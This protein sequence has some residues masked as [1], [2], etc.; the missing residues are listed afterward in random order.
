V[1]RIASSEAL[2]TDSSDYSLWR[3]Y[4]AKRR[5]SSGEAK[6]RYAFRSIDFSGTAAIRDFSF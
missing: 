3:D 4:E 6:R 2:R 5:H 1:R